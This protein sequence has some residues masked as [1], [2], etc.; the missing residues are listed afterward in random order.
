M[1]GPRVFDDNSFCVE[2]TRGS[3]TGLAERIK[4]R[5]GPLSCTLQDCLDQGFRLQCCGTYRPELSTRSIYKIHLIR[6]N[7]KYLLGK[8]SW[9]DLAIDTDLVLWVNERRYLTAG[10]GIEPEG[11]KVIERVLVQDT[12]IGNRSLYEVLTEKLNEINGGF[13]A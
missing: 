12:L 1:R 11:E 6:K 8:V 3:V 13:N 5:F 2:A 10:W 4:L 7:E 9:A